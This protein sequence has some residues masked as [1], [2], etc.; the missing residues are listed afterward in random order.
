MDNEQCALR[1]GVVG[2]LRPEF[3]AQADRVHEILKEFE[4]IIVA[5]ANLTSSTPDRVWTCLV[6]KASTD[7]LGAFTGRL[8]LV[9]DVRVKSFL[10]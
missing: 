2:L 4:S 9:K 8:G 6:V 10:V 7:A 5:M 3:G 1:Q